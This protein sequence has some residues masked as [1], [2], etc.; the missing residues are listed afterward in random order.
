MRKRHVEPKAR[1]VKSEQ[2]RRKPRPGAPK[3]PDADFPA[4][5][6]MNAELT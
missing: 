2:A 4:G 6:S 5:L 3:D 1:T